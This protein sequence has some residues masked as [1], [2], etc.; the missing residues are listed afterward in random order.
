MAFNAFYPLS[1]KQHTQ[2]IAENILNNLYYARAEAI[3]HNQVVQVCGSI[4]GL[5]C[6][7]N[8]D[9]GFIV[10]RLSHNKSA[11]PDILR[12]QIY[13]KIQP[14]IYTHFNKG[15]DS[16]NFNPSGRAQ[17]CGRLIIKNKQSQ[18]RIIIYQSGRIRIVST[19]PTI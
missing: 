9:K 4:D 5:H 14:R 15:A 18:K 13:Q 7:K 11:L 12:T 6:S 1:E 19:Y 17:L 2:L 8:W 16:I 3:K 10:Q